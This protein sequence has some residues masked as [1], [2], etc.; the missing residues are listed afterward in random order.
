MT[1]CRKC[2]TDIPRRINRCPGCGALVNRLLSY[3]KWLI[4]AVAG[5]FVIVYLLL[6]QSFV[7]LKA[8]LKLTGT[9]FIITNSGDFDWKNVKMDINGGYIKQVPVMSAGKAYTFRCPEFAKVEGYPLDIYKIQKPLFIL[10]CDTPRGKALAEI[11]FTA[12]LTERT[13][14]FQPQKSKR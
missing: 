8:G 12:A 2:G 14:V 3:E 5:W 11:D 13:P 1:Q 6:H 4:L 7:P 10:T 9:E